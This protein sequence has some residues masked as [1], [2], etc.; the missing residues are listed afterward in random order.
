M[1]RRWLTIAFAV[2]VALNLF[3][4]GVAAARFWQHREWRTRRWGDPALNMAGGAAGPARPDGHRGP[5]RR[6]PFPWLSQQEKEELRPKRQA[7]V[8]ARRDAEQVLVADPLDA[9]KLGSA[10]ETVRAQ[11]ARLQ[12]SVHERLIQHAQSMGLEERRKLA[13]M[14]WGTPGERGRRPPRVPEGT[15]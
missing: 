8:E 7:L 2:S 3:F 15:H 11:T 12:A 9:A 13:D 1:T 5:R 6:E 4:L 10:L 14:S